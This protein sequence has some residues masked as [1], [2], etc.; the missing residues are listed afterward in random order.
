MSGTR[1]S[2]KAREDI[3]RYLPVAACFVLVLGGSSDAQESNLERAP[4]PPAETVISVQVGELE[5]TIRFEH[6]MINDPTVSTVFNHPGDV[7]VTPRGKILWLDPA[8]QTVHVLSGDGDHE[9]DIGEAGQGPG[10]FESPWL[11]TADPSSRVHVFDRTRGSI[12]TFRLDG[13]FLIRRRLPVSASFRATGMEFMDEDTLVMSGVSLRAPL[14]GYGVHIF[15]VR[16]DAITYERSFAETPEMDP[17]LYRKYAYGIARKDFDGGL[18]Y[19]QIT[20]YS[21]RKYNVDG[22]LLWR[23]DDPELVPA[24]TESFEV[25]PAG[26]IRAR[27]YR[28][29]SSVLPVKGTG[30]LHMIM[31]PPSDAPENER[32]LYQRLFELIRCCDEQGHPTGRLRFKVAHPLRYSAVDQQGRLYGRWHEWDYR[33]I[34]SF[35]SVEDA[36]LEELK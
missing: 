11:V 7:A 22:E 3:L 25:S 20:P 1:R 14:H 2:R 28:Y 32:V 8:D 5:R 10:R 34:R 24:A 16:D 21:V 18:L 23:I 30:Y 27:R 9:R 33:L 13:K 26:R 4:G 36:E 6:E 35:V 12:E 31:V 29:S 19:N 17:M 15:S